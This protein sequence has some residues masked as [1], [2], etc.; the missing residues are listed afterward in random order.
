MRIAIT[1][2]TGLVGGHLTRHLVLTG[3]EVVLI[4]RGNPRDTSILAM[5]GA[6]PS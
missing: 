3:H 1:G 2:G 4:A 6:T 5:P